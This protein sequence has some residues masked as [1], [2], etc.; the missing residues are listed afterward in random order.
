MHALPTRL[1]TQVC[2]SFPVCSHLD[3][4][5]SAPNRNPQPNC[6]LSHHGLCGV[7]CLLQACI[8][9]LLTVLD[10]ALHTCTLFLFRSVLGNGRKCEMPQSLRSSHTRLHHSVYS[11]VSEVLLD[12]VLLD[13]SLTRD[14]LNQIHLVLCGCFDFILIYENSLTFLHL[15]LDK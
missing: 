3:P 15:Y 12:S 10:F 11:A 2:V 1:L 13:K 14:I 5:S 9:N 4:R 7:K 6:Q 8:W